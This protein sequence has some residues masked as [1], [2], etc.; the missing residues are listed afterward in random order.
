MELVGRYSKIPN[1]SKLPQF[2]TLE[3]EHMAHKGHDGLV[4]V[5]RVHAVERRLTAKTIQQI[6]DEYNAGATSNNLMERYGLG[7]GPVLDLLHRHG[8]T[9]R[10]RGGQ[11][12]SEIERAVHL[13]QAG[14]SVAKIGVEVGRA[15]TVIWRALKKRGVELRPR[16]GWR[17]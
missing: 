9:V 6:V 10:T 5:T 1:T 17:N 15:P 12:P 8:A 13:Y 3:Y 2:L 14:W 16:N 7:K 11:S 4:K